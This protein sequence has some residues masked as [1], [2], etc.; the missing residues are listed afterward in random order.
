MFC[1]KMEVSG[2]IETFMAPNG[3]TRLEV[4][5][6]VGLS[7]VIYCCR[8]VAGQ[9][10]IASCPR[11]AWARDRVRGQSVSRCILMKWNR[12]NRPQRICTLPL[13]V[14]SC[15]SRRRSFRSRPTI[16]SLV[17]ELI[18]IIN[19]NN[20][21]YDDGARVCVC[22]YVGTCSCTFVDVRRGVELQLRRLIGTRVRRRCEL[23]CAG[24][25][26]REE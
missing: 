1:V 21:L 6:D 8:L 10:M 5:G 3:Q 26:I 11:R 20:V 2:R 9:V 16:N 15:L 25:F 13:C 17:D 12:S 23:S 19:D 24:P 14:G 18:A 7:A 4:V 22:L